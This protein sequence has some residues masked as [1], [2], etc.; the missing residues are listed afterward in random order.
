M[1]EDPTEPAVQVTEWPFYWLTRAGVAYADAMTSALQGTG[2][3]MPSWRVVMVLRDAEWMSVS[4]IAALSNSKLAAMTKTVQRMKADAL[5]ETRESS[6]DRRVTEVT[7]TQT[8]RHAAAVGNQAA[9]RVAHRAFYHMS[10]R[11]QQQLSAL[12]ANVVQ[13]LR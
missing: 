7:L 9:S 4:E 10:D 1:T 12:L 5:V 11:D 8:G 3:D 6:A 2:L 13:N